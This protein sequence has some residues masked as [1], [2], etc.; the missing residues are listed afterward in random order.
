MS[1]RPCVLDLRSQAQLM[2]RFFL[3]IKSKQT[4]KHQKIQVSTV[5]TKT[6]HYVTNRESEKDCKTFDCNFHF[7]FFKKQQTLKLTTSNS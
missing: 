1:I 7:S 5:K 4:K 3:E 6:N 2:S